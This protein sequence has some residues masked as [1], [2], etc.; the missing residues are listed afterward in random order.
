MIR[1][2]LCGGI[3]DEQLINVLDI[4]NQA[5]KEQEDLII[6]VNSEGGDAHIAQTI[7][8]ALM[9]STVQIEIH[10]LQ[11]FSSAC[12][13]FKLC[14]ADNIKR[15]AT[16]ASMFMDHPGMTKGII[17]K[18]GVNYHEV[19]AERD[20]YLNRAALRNFADTDPDYFFDANEA[21]EKGYI[22]EIIDI[23]A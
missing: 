17:S 16:Q 7:A 18:N 6:Y 19:I 23:Y 8:H 20:K 3:D 11:V 2:C 21:L 22:D 9:Y 15:Y 13:L 10:G 4:I 12:R 5:E 1:Y 14:K